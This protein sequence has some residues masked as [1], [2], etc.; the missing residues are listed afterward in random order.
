LEQCS[1]WL[2]DSVQKNNIENEVASFATDSIITTK[3]LDLDS[4]TLGKFAYENSGTD[5]YVL[6][7]GI[8]GSMENGKKGQ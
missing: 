3:K 5:V 2:Y 6:Q 7:N 8:I 1:K 4:T